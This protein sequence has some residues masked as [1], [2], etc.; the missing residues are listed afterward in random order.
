MAAFLYKKM[1]EQGGL[2]NEREKEEKQSVQ[3]AASSSD[4]CAGRNFVFIYIQ[5]YSNVRSDH[6]DLKIMI[7]LRV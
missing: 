5:L 6:W 7:S 3:T 2:D 4:V 1:D